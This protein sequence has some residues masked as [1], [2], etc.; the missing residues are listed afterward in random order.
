MTVVLAEAEEGYGRGFEVG[1]EQGEEEGVR[2]E[3]RGL[4][5][6]QEAGGCGWEGEELGEGGAR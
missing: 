3:V 6:E 2:G 5:D 1:E 4:E